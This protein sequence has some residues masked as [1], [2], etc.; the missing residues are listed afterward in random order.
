MPEHTVCTSCGAVDAQR[1]EENAQFGARN[2]EDLYEHFRRPWTEREI[3]IAINPD[4]GPQEAMRQLAAEG[5]PRPYAAIRWMRV[6]HGV[7]PR[8]RG[9]P[10]KDIM[11]ILAD[12]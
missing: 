5:Y 6:K 8:K 4:I 11:A 2:D 3:E 9:R 10:R 7:P 1:L 12:I